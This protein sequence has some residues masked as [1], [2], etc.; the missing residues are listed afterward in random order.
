MS[1]PLVFGVGVN[2]A[3]YVVSPSRSE[4]GKIT[5][6][7]I[8]PIY[9][10]WVAILRRCYHAPSRPSRPSYVGCTVANEWHRFSAFKSWMESQDWQGKDVDKDLLVKGNKVYGPDTCCLISRSINCLVREIAKNAKKEHSLPPGVDFDPKLQKYRSRAHCVITGKRNHFGYFATPAEA[11]L[12]WLRFKRDQAE[13]LAQE[14]ADQRVANA[15]RG[16]YASDQPLH[17]PPTE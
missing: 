17:S 12:V 6:K 9:A 5:F 4:N 8:C 13:I 11:H 15:L 14:Q 3:D 2:D 1:H 10:R 16:L 7:Y